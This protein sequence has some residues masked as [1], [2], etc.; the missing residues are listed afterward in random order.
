VVN[1][2]GSDAPIPAAEEA[3]FKGKAVLYFPS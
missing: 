2:A 3:G 1:F